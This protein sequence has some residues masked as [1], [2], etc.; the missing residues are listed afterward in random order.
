MRVFA[1]LLVLQL[2]ACDAPGE[3]SSIDSTDV[4]L[5]TAD[6]AS[7]G[8][9]Q[10]TLVTTLGAITVTLDPDH[11]PSTVDNFMRYASSGFYDGDDGFGATTFHRV[12]EDFMIQGGGYTVDGVRKE[13][14]LPIDIES[15]NGLSNMRGTIAMARTNDPNSATSQFFINQVDNDYLDYSDA[16]SP[17]YTVFGVVTAGMDVVDA[18]AS[19]ETNTQD[20]PSATSIIIDDLITWLD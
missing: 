17:G 10:V 1:P 16:S 20:E 9:Y 3:S 11:A 19:V 5:D 2:I 4:E 14:L 12:I 8:D 7:L 18:I 13:T 6:T 15:N